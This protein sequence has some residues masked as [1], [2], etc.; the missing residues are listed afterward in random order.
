MARMYRVG[1]GIGDVTDP[2]VG[3]P[4]VGMADQNQ[5][6]TGVESPLYARAFVVQDAA[7][8]ARV[9]II[10]ADIWAGTRRVK[11]AVIRRLA[12]KHGALF[13]DENVL[14]AGTHTHSG[15]GGFSGMLLYD[16]TNGGCDDAVVTCI[17]E[18]C[19]GAVEMANANLA[20]GRIY[21]NRGEVEDCGRNRSA[22]ACLRN[23]EAEQDHRGASTDREM[24]L[25]KFVQ[26]DSRGREWPVGV[27]NWYAIHP[28]DRGQK[29]TLVCGDNKGFAS[30]LFEHKMEAD[31][32]TQQTFVAAFANANCGDVSVSVELGHIPDGI[33]DRVQMEKHGRQQ[34]E[35]AQRLFETATEEVTGPI[36]HR[37]TRVDFS[38]VTV[39]RDGTRT[40]PAAL[41]VSF[42]AGSSEDSVPVPN[43]GVR[44]GIAA[45]NISAAEALVSE[46]MRAALSAIVGVNIVQ[47]TRAKAARRGHLP[48]PV[49]VMPGIE[50][51]PAV[52][53]VL[54]VQLLRIGTVAILGVPGELTT[55]AGRRLRRTVLDTMSASGV[56]HVALGTYANEYSQYITTFEEYCHQ[57]Y[58]GASTL[59][60]PHTLKAYQQVAAGLAAAIAQNTP[61]APGPQP[62]PWTAP[63]QHRYR[64]RNLSSSAVELKFYNCRDRKHWVTLP[65]GTKTIGAGAELAFPEREFTGHM[66]PTIRRLT[67]ETTDELELEMAAG[68]L[69]TVA[70]DG[71]VSVDAYTPPPRH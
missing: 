60:G 26:V 12:E 35:A 49:V 59:F 6:S 55:I 13:N 71:S 36:D 50:D 32:R 17:V 7:T 57:H 2:A 11:E 9:T 21:V 43:M 47:Y 39:Q 56:S 1:T 64:F 37:H 38:K 70:V 48:K 30:A 62:N 51:P 41:G 46:A 65:N 61:A 4:L 25:L 54:P 18:G 20:P 8:D 40:W 27:L 15:P 44:E 67:V 24:L 31:H 34:F 10:I 33:G 14:L 19:V 66:L 23:P 58:E 16:Y 63:S 3:L 28:T 29:N 52:P 22:P 68:Q 45:A 5:I 53:Q 42:A 69:L